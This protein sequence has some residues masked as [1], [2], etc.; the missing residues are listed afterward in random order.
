M[1][2]KSELIIA[3]LLRKK[4]IPYRHEYPLNLM[5]PETQ[6]MK[7]IYP[8]FMILRVRDRKVLFWEHLGLL[9]K[10]DYFRKNLSKIRTYEMNGYL[11]GYSL[12]I[13]FETSFADV[14]ITFPSG[15]CFVPRPIPCNHSFSLPVCSITG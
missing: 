1:R 2:S 9:E 3:D 14:P 13:S 5:D 11:P 4:R 10:P 6:H 15:V 8:D 12:I 7:T